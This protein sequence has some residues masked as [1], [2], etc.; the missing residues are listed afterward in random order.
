MSKDTG[1][2]R[3]LDKLGRIVIP[4]EIRET[5]QI[6]EKSPVQIFVKNDSIIL[7]KYIPT[8]V[9]CGNKKNLIKFN[10]RLVC[11]E[12]VKNIDKLNKS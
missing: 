1:I 10:D 9:F 8:C 4:V 2:I 6:F 11:D 12:C 7:K 3:K 5:L